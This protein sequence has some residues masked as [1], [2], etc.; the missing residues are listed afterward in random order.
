MT[1]L[2]KRFEGYS[3]EE[4][5]NKFDYEPDVSSIDILLREENADTD[6]AGFIVSTAWLFT[7]R[8]GNQALALQGFK[9]D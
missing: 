2:E 8:D 5:I 6:F 3:E 1:K 4:E 7:D 9:I